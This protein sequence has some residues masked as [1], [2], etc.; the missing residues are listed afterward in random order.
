MGRKKNNS[1][2]NVRLARLEA[3]VEQRAKKAQERRELYQWYKERGICIRCQTNKA[4]GGILCPACREKNNLLRRGKPHKPLT[5]EQKARNNQWRVDKR[6]KN[7]ADGICTYCGKYKALPGLRMCFGC[8]SYIN[9]Y[10][11]GYV[12]HSQ[13]W[14]EKERKAGRV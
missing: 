9:E 3:T 1:F 11:S 4:I 5:Q 2:E 7:I 14:W 8:R 12:E 6:K 13:K 10:R